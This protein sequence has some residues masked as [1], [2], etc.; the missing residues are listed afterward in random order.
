[1]AP[2]RSQYHEEEFGDQIHWIEQMVER[3]L[4]YSD[5]MV[6][7]GEVDERRT[8][9]QRMSLGVAEPGLELGIPVAADLVPE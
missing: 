1:M 7:E 8:E 6:P 3:N 2:A 4:F 9:A 5:T